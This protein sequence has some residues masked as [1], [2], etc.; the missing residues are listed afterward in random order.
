MAELYWS[1]HQ[2]TLSPAAEDIGDVMGALAQSMKQHG[3]AGVQQGSDVHGYRV[4]I[5]LYASVLYLFIG[6]RNFWQVIMVGGDA[7]AAQAQQ[8]IQALQAIISGLEF[9]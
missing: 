9:L 6:G 2:Y 4:G 3:W 1:A 5:D 8:E 7:T